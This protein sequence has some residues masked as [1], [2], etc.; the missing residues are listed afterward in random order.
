[1]SDNH[2]HPMRLVMTQNIC[3]FCNTHNDIYEY[4]YGSMYD[5]WLYC[6]KCV[7]A[8]EESIAANYKFRKEFDIRRF[9]T[10]YPSIDT[11]IKYSVKRTSG[12]IQSDWILSKGRLEPMIHLI[13]KDNYQTRTYDHDSIIVIW[14]SRASTSSTK[15]IRLTEFYELNAVKLKIPIDEFRRRALSVII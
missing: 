2:K 14:L 10:L 6:G 13:N 1:M 9:K 5:G 12:E 3:Q 7:D 8:L 15:A 4:H 11:T